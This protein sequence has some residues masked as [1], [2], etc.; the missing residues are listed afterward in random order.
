MCA[1]RVRNGSDE[2]NRRKLKRLTK[3]ETTKRHSISVET[4][5][6]RLEEPAGVKNSR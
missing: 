5:Q 4:G 1:L 2:S 3:L 6:S